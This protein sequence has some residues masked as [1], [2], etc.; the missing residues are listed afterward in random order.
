MR[1]T[2]PTEFLPRHYPFSQN[3]GAPLT[4]HDATLRSEN[5]YVIKGAMCNN[6][7][8]LLTEIQYKIHNCVH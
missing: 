2:I 1:T 4:H 8:D 6:S 5:Q 7:E 3:C